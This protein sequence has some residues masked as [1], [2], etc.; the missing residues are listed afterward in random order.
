PVRDGV[1]QG[2][3]AAA[4]RFRQGDGRSRYRGQGRSVRGPQLWRFRRPRSVSPGYRRCQWT[5]RDRGRAALPAD[6]VP[7]GA[8]PEALRRRGAPAVRV[9]LRGD[10]AGLVRGAGAQHGARSVRPLDM[11]M[12]PGQVVPLL[13]EKPAAG[14]RMIARVDRQ[15]VLV[16]GAIPGERLTARVERIGKDV[17]YA[18][19][20]SIEEA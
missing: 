10:G 15:V 1:R 7:L 18:Q 5:V 11:S 17:V 19:T 9:V 13:V 8:E 14:G 12:T 6:R 4:S 16:S 3:Q 2:Q 20:L